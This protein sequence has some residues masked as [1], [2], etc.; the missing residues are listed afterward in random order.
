MQF[1]IDLRKLKTIAALLVTVGM[2]LPQR[3]CNIT[4]WTE[5]ETASA[6]TANVVSP[7]PKKLLW[8]VRPTYYHAVASQTDERYWETADG[9]D[10]RGFSFQDTIYIA[11]PQ[12]KWK[13][14]RKYKNCYIGDMPCKIVDK[15]NNRYNKH[16]RIDILLPKKQKLSTSDST[17][18]EL[19]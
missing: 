5:I 17:L 10:V 18:V 6:T 16:N 9:S 3:A 2:L 14:L 15:L 11:V 19:W 4:T 13:R 8:K 12:S 7:P 1:T